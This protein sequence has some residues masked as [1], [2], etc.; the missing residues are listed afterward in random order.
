MTG[1]ITDNLLQKVLLLQLNKISSYTG[2]WE[3]F[4]VFIDRDT[5]DSFRRRLI[6]LLGAGAKTWHFYNIGITSRWITMILFGGWWAK[7]MEYTTKV[8]SG[9][10]MNTA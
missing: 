1:Q 6:Y 9:D 4:N 5:M 3:P 7:A 2:F 10:S 8:V